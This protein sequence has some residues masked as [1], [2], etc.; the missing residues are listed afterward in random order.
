MGRP[1]KHDWRKLFSD[2]GGDS[3]EF[4]LVRGVDYDCSDLMMVQTVRN[5][6]SSHGGLAVSFQVDERNPGT[7]TAFV[8]P[9]PPGTARPPKKRSKYGAVK[10]ECDGVT[11]DSKKEAKRYNELKLLLLAGEIEHLQRQPAFPITVNGVKVG[12]YKADFS[13]MEKGELVIEDVKSEPTKTAVYRLK[14]KLVEA[15]YGVRITEV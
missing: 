11:F 12:T 15:M 3:F 8:A 2:V 6:A 10:T 9:K 14:K 13:Y 4:T 7:V 1:K 5:H